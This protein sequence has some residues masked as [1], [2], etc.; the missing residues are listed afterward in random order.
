M[1]IKCLLILL[2][3]SSSFLTRTVRVFIGYTRT[4]KLHKGKARLQMS[5][6]ERRGTVVIFPPSSV[7]QLLGGRP[8][9]VR[10]DSSYRHGP[11]RL[12]NQPLCLIGKGPSIVAAETCARRVPL[13]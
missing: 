5:W 4:V 10:E 6:Y 13:W 12:G 7:H 9:C 11:P 2:G 1:W 3:K 8:S